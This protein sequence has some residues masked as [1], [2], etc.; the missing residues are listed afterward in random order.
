[1]IILNNEEVDQLEALNAQN[2]GLNRAIKAI[3]LSEDKHAVNTDI[4][5]DPTTWRNWIEFLAS[6]PTEEIELPV[7][8]NDNIEDSLE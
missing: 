5:T 3:E 1:M 2:L 8:S 6:K 4:L 7:V